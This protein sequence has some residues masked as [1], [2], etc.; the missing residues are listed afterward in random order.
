MF[1]YVAN[2]PVNWIDPE[3]KLGIAPALPWIIDGAVAVGVL[4]MANKSKAPDS[5]T[6]QKAF[7]AV[8]KVCS[9]GSGKDFSKCF[10]RALGR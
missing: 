7:Y 2:D 8:L 5:R 10:K 6:C 1:G 3:G 9:R 4:E